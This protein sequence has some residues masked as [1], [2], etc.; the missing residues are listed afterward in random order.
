MAHSGKQERFGEVSEEREVAGREKER[1]PE[2]EGG[3][4]REGAEIYGPPDSSISVAFQRTD[5]E[6][7]M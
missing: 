7:T 6:Y 1:E 2:E 4:L 3:R 5:Y